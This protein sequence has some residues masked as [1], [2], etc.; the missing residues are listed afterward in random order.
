M[1]PVAPV[2]PVFA[3]VPAAPVAPVGPIGPIGPRAETPSDGALPDVVVGTRRPICE[4]RSTSLPSPR[5]MKTL[6]L[7]DL[8]PLMRIETSY[9]Q[10]S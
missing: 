1:L 8:T 5:G 9:A 4:K 7:V 6:T 3:A 2:A 10:T